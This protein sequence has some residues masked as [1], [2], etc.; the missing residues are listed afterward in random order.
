[1][2]LKQ[3]LGVV[4]AASAVATTSSAFA[5]T[6]M[7]HTSTPRFE[8]GRVEDTPFGQQ[9]D[10]KKVTRTIRVTMDDSMRFHPENITVEQGET[11]RFVIPNAGAVLHEMVLGTPEALKEH[12][13]LMKKHPGME[14]D[15]PSMAHVKPGTAGEIV[16]RFTKAGEFQFA[17]LIPGHFEAGMVGKVRVR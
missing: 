11:V 14:H 3:V 13:E 1:M 7:P 4:I 2:K 9:G 16:W 10:P 17:C 6:D 8:P 15:E 12:A 5:H